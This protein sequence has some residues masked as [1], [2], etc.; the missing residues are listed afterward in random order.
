M[1]FLISSGE[2][3][4]VDSKMSVSSLRK[5]VQLIRVALMLVL[6]TSFSA[7]ELA[8]QTAAA[9]SADSKTGSM[10]QH[11]PS[12]NVAPGKKPSLTS[13][14]DDPGS[15]QIEADIRKLHVL[16]AELRAEVAKTYKESLSVDVLKKA[17]EIEILSK[18]L[19]ER[20]EQKAAAAR[21]R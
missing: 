2:S 18:S 5:N 7:P 19:K 13:V 12:Q 11:P 21:H 15:D 1:A 20:M 17:K 10:N 9:T 4:S 6:L 8:S 16:S 14:P 3:P